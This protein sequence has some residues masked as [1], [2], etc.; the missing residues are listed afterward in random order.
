MG[1][2]DVFSNGKA[3]VM[4]GAGY[5]SLVNWDNQL[6]RRSNILGFPKSSLVIATRSGTITNT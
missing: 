5:G 3:V 6:A 1:R 2:I 4:H